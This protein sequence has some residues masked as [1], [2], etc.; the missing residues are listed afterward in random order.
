MLPPEQQK[1]YTTTYEGQN[2]G[3][4]TRNEGFVPVLDA[5]RK[6]IGICDEDGIAV[7]SQHN[8]IITNLMAQGSFVLTKEV[9]GTIPPDTK[10][11]FGLRIED[12]VTGN[13]TVR[14]RPTLRSEAT[15]RG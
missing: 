10:F 14:Y 1:I 15:F 3:Q 8:V 5:E 2:K 6:Q 4:N 11:Q 12:Y 13:T 7:G 9:Q